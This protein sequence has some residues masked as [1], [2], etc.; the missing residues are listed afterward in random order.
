M[1]KRFEEYLE[2]TFRY[3]PY[4]KEALDLKEEL[5]SSLLE[6]SEEL[7]ES[8][9][10]EEEIFSECVDSLGDY[11]ETIKALKRNPLSL[12]KDTK[13]QKGVLGLIIFVLSAVML[14][15]VLGVTLN[16]W[17]Q[18]ALIIF[19]TMAVIIYLVIAGSILLRNIKF[20]RH[21]T[22]GVIIASVF[23]IYI[24]AF[25]FLLFGAFH[26]S[27]G[28]IWVLFTYIP[29]L[30]ICAHL[31]A[32]GHLRKKKIWL[33][34]W[35]LLVLLVL[36]PIYLTLSVITGLWHPLWLIILLGVIIDLVIFTFSLKKK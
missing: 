1:Q 18:G 17:G 20:K 33:G 22:S 6:R 23:V 34:V 36:V 4:S 30:I 24:T 28:K 13:F 32:R 16:F 21:F 19:P 29:A 10:T 15:V 7:K 8:G 2:K 26:M 5:L 9:K 25:F 12:L 14:Y 11:T 3:L 31:I 27:A 35:L